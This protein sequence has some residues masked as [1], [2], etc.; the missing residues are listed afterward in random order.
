MIYVDCLGSQLRSCI[1]AKAR[2]ALKISSIEP[3]NTASCT[4]QYWLKVLR[5]VAGEAGL[6]DNQ[7]NNAHIEHF[8]DL[9]GRYR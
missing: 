2:Y 6:S 8:Q 7:I 1:V 4:Q 9:I 5:I 3:L